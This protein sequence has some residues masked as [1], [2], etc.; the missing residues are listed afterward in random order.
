MLAELDELDATSGWVPLFQKLNWIAKENAGAQKVAKLP[1]NRQLNR[2]RDVLPYDHSRV[3]LN[4]E[5]GDTDYINANF[6]EVPLVERKYILAQGPLRHTSHHFWQMVW[7]QKSKAVIMLNRVIEK[8]QIKCY[9]YWPCGE[10]VGHTNTLEFGNF[11]ITYIDENMSEFFTVKT[12]ELYNIKKDEKRTIYHYHYLHWPDFGV[13][14]S[15]GTFLS[16]LFEAR[17]AGVISKDVGPAVIHCSAGIGRSGTYIMVDSILKEVEK[18]GN[19]NGVD[20]KKTLLEIRKYRLGLIQTPDQLRFTY[21]AILEGTHILLPNVYEEALD[22]F[23]EMRKGKLVNDGCVMEEEAEEEDEE[24]PPLPP[25]RK[26]PDTQPTEEDNIQAKRKRSLPDIPTETSTSGEASNQEASLSS[27]E[28]DGEDE[29]IDLSASSTS[30]LLDDEEDDE[31]DGKMKDEIKENGE[32]E[33]KED[34][35]EENN[36]LSKNAK[37]ISE[38]SGTHS[39][40]LNTARVSQNSKTMDNKLVENEK[41]VRIPEKIE[42][43]VGFKADTANDG[44][45][46]NDIL[47]GTVECNQASPDRIGISQSVGGIMGV[48]PHETNTDTQ[49][50]DKEWTGKIAE[51]KFTDDDY[52]EPSTSKESEV[53]LRRR[54]RTE[55]KQKT[56]KLVK[57]IKDRVKHEEDSRWIRSIV[58]KSLI[59]LAVCSV[60]Y[61]AYRCY[62]YFTWVPRPR[63]RFPRM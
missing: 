33:G 15:P 58:K 49:W 22:K 57:D 53:E 13:P 8:N 12:L 2:Y 38:D 32:S 62:R 21:D 48:N 20:I 36:K 61:L 4:A 54:Q 63:R 16:F 44:T 6:V 24:P 50:K 9:Q 60:A 14:T 40:E 59:A 39:M 23:L 11:K 37:R 41:T 18:T 45:I 56:A 10:K 26:R 55:K 30:S 25:P 52:L 27:D 51:S 3:V 46:K 34:I 47:P 5:D 29:I 35:S 42:C 19:L 17:N 28:S 7:E 1:E 31:T 43:T